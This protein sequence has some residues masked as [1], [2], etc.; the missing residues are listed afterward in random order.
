MRL[1]DHIKLTI[2]RYVN[3]QRNSHNH[4]LNDES[5]GSDERV[6]FAATFF[7]CVTLNHTGK[8]I[9]N[10]LLFKMKHACSELT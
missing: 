3:T 2:K 1:T 7:N 4:I 6:Y 8:I 10:Y 5:L 9:H